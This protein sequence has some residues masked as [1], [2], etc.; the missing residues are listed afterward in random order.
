[1]LLKGFCL[2]NHIDGEHRLYDLPVIE[3]DEKSELFKQCLIL[4]GVSEGNRP[5][6]EK[7]IVSNGLKNKM[8]ISQLFDY[9]YAL[10]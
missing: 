2:S 10:E 9:M 3:F 8:I 6:I 4:I 7:T 5:E 1:M